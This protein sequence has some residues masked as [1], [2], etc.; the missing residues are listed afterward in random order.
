MTDPSLR[1]SWL[2]PSLL[3]VLVPLVLLALGLIFWS[4]GLLA[5]LS[6]FLI[7]LVLAYVFNPVVTWLEG[8]LEPGRTVSRLAATAVFSLLASMVVLVLGIAVA[9]VAAS[10]VRSLAGNLSRYFDALW[11]SRAVRVSLD[12]RALPAGWVEIIEAT[13]TVPARLVVTAVI[14]DNAPSGFLAAIVDGERSVPFRLP[15]QPQEAT[16]E[17]AASSAPSR[18]LRIVDVERRDRERSSPDGGAVLR[19]HLEGG[20]AAVPKPAR[21]YWRVGDLLSPELTR[22]LLVQLRP[23][24]LRARLASLLSGVDYVTAAQSA[25]SVAA[26]TLRA[27]TTVLSGIGAGTAAVFHFLSL[28]GLVVIITFYL[29]LD[30]ERFKGFLR[31][32]V[33]AEHREY[34]FRLAAEIDTQ[35][36][37]FLRGQATI[38]LVVGVLAAGGLFILSWFFPVK[39]PILIGLI[40][41]AFNIV[42]YLGPFMGLVPALLLTWAEVYSTGSGGVLWP[43][44]AILA[45]FGLIQMLDGFLISPRIMGNTVDMHPMVIL[46]ALL[47]GGQMLGMIGML[48]AVPAACVLRVILRDIYVPKDLPPTPAPV[49][50]NPQRPGPSKRKRP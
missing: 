5:V 36:G 11:S 12:G 2:R 25:G 30:F 22:D 24:R 38:C 35:L 20:P 46:L 39:Y 50:E 29:L 4:D 33:P 28:T 16:M 18:A 26:G 15:P 9:A 7:S 32:L 19:L 48:L 41:G 31:K 3:K 23:D 44:L 17:Q 14:P 40:A 8:S 34:V 13:G 42:P 21:H 6:P 27:T 43:T 45:L 1:A 10:E 47:A 49:R 37:G